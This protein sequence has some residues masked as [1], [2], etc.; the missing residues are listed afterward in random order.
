M[1]DAKFKGVFEIK[2]KPETIEAVEEKHASNRRK[3]METATYE[4]LDLINGK[5]CKMQQNSI[6]LI[7]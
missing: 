7:K 4:K 1:H 3:R 6:S 2:K 5:N